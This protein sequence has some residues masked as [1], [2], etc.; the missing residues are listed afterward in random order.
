MR[1]VSPQVQ[2]AVATV[3]K[4]SQQ[5][6]WPLQVPCIGCSPEVRTC[7]CGRSGA[8]RSPPSHCEDSTRHGDLRPVTPGRLDADT[9]GLATN[10]TCVGSTRHHDSDQ[11]ELYPGIMSVLRTIALVQ[12]VPDRAISP[13]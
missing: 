3:E 4:L 7:R 2:P 1:S 13:P 9:V 8:A 5:P 12:G 10:H 6:P 11:L